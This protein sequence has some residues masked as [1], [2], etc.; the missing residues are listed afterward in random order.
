MQTMEQ[1]GN[2]VQVG[3]AVYFFPSEQKARIFV[4]CLG[5]FL[6]PL[7]NENGHPLFDFDFESPTFLDDFAETVRGLTVIA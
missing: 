7:Y 6:T 1:V 4:I 2:K 3:E 5:S